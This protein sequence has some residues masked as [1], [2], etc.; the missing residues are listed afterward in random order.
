MT[1]EPFKIIPLSEEEKKDMREL[2]DQFL[3]LQQA[4]GRAQR[5]FNEALR[6]ITSREQVPDGMLVNVNL[7]QGVLEVYEPPQQRRI[8]TPGSRP[9]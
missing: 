1:N 2:D 8:I 7:E 9:H 3:G 5:L 4:I 6:R